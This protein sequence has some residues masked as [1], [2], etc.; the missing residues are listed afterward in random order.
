MPV[1]DVGEEALRRIF[2]ERGFQLRR[3]VLSRGQQTTHY[4]AA[5]EKLGK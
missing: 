4:F 1:M 3:W 5:L 2:S